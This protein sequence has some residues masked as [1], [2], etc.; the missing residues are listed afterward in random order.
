MLQRCNKCGELHPTDECDKM[1]AADP[2]CANCGEKHRA[3][4]KDCP[5]CAEFVEIRKRTSTKNQPMRRAVPPPALNERN[6]PAITPPRRPIPVLPPLQPHKRLTA[7]AGSVP[8]ATPNGFRRQDKDGQGQ[9]EPLLAER[10]PPF[11]TSEQLVSIFT[12]LASRLRG[13]KTRFDQVFTSHHPHR[14]ILPNAIQGD[15]W[16]IGRP[17]QRHR[18]TNAAPRAVHHRR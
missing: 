3:T 1:E 4:T 16:D 8:S 2:K 13:C 9:D 18:Q 14:G 5:K 11:Y 7:A 15:R 17:P 10:D 12:Q 6:F